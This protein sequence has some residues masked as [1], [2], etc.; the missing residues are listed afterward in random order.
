[1]VQE[2]PCRFFLYAVFFVCGAVSAS[3]GR[4]KSTLEVARGVAWYVLK[5]SKFF[6]CMFVS[7]YIRKDQDNFRTNHAR[8]MPYSRTREQNKSK[9][10]IE[11]FNGRNIRI[12]T[13]I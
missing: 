5:E 2:K 4:R 1:M 12:N 8:R 10:E 6:W 9:G 13:V 3:M 7:K 11:V